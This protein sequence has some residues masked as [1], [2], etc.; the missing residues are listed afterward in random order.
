MTRVIL[1]DRRSEAGA[2]ERS[3]N[4]NNVR[5]LFVG[6]GT[7]TRAP[8]RQRGHRGHRSRAAAPASVACLIQSGHDQ[9]WEPVLKDRGTSLGWLTVPLKFSREVT[10]T[11]CGKQCSPSRDLSG[12][13]YGLNQLH[14]FQILQAWGEMT[15]VTAPSALSPLHCG[16]EGSATS[17]SCPL[18]THTWP[19]KRLAL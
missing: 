13:Y 18:P 12:C 14:P 5:F 2:P 7:Y 9:F 1:K 19:D 17:A 4:Q 11:L 6:A 8:E 16:G 3:I 15:P 10:G